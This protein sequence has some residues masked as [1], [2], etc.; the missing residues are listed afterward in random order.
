VNPTPLSGLYICEGSSDL[1]LA[2]IVEYLYA[3]RGREL[4]LSRPDYATL[5]G[6][7]RDVRSKLVAGAQLMDGPFNLAV[8]HRDADQAGWQARRAEI[9]DALATSEIECGLTPVIP[10]TMTEAWLLLDEQEIR[11]VAGNP[12]GRAPISLPKRHEVEGIA[13]PKALLRECLLQAAS[14][15]GRRRETV[16]K[17]FPQHRAQLLER[18]DIH[19]PVTGLSSWQSLIADVERCAEALA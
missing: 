16:S 15:R 9:E 5:R 11:V 14:M 13:D 6:V 12:N 2:D 19:G 4:Q 18:L 8:V 17:R 1:P 7:G 10:I 3:E